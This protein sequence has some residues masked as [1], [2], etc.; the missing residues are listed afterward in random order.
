M[1]CELNKYI[2][3]DDDFEVGRPI[4]KRQQDVTGRSSMFGA[5]MSATDM[6]DNMHASSEMRF[7]KPGQD[8]LSEDTSTLLKNKSLWQF[9]LK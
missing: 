8:Q 1:E 9:L 6:G 3:Y 4:L 5:N 7:F 2:Y